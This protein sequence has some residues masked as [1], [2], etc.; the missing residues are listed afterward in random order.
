MKKSYLPVLL[1]IL[2]GGMVSCKKQQEGAGKNVS[3]KWQQVKL[4]VYEVHNDTV[5]YDTTYYHPFSA[6]DFIQFNSNG[7]CLV[8]TD[9]YYYDTAP[10][11]P[12]IPQA[13]PPQ[14][15]TFD[16]SYN[17][18]IYILSQTPGLSNPGGFVTTDTAYLR[19]QDTLHEKVTFY[20]HSI[21]SN[22]KSVS[23]ADYIKL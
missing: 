16:Y 4:R 10:G 11:W 12:K 8:G 17:G 14:S 13:I 23:E 19:Q 2:T 18:S 21:T 22:I 6:A 1:I 7:T 9:H 15:S 20:G 3:S 5:K